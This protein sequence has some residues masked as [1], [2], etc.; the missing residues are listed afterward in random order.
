MNTQAL[1][2]AVNRDPELNRR[3]K[4]YSIH[5]KLEMDDHN[6]VFE[7]DNGTLASVKE[8]SGDSVAFSLSGTAE[9]WQQ[10]LSHEPPPG[11]HDIA[12]MI[13]GGHLALTGDPM[14]WLAN[15]LYIKGVIAHWKQAHAGN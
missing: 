7:V 12:A 9:A 11:H 14:P 6:I 5:F 15:M 13:D 4:Y 3:G 8:N 1:M 10:F 2:N